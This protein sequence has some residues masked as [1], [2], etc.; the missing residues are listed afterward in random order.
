[1][2]ICRSGHR[3]QQRGLNLCRR[4]VD[5][6]SQYQ[7]VEQGP[8]LEHEAA[9]PGRNISVPVRSAGSRSGVNWIL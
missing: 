8:A 2:V 6:V 4:P 3:F 5:F 7:I 1:M 9:V